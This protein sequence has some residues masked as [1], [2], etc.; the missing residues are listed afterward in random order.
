MKILL[1]KLQSEWEN[2]KGKFNNI[3][4]AKYKDQCSIDIYDDLLDSSNR[5]IFRLQMQSFEQVNR[6]AFDFILEYL[7]TK[8]LEESDILQFILDKREYKS[9]KNK[10]KVVE[11]TNGGLK[12]D[13]GF[14]LIHV[15][16]SWANVWADWEVLNDQSLF[17]KVEFDYEILKSCQSVENSGINIHSLCGQRFFVPCYEG[18]GGYYTGS[19]Y[20]KL[21]DSNG[22]LLDT[23]NFTEGTKYLP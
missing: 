18:T 20:L 5:L 22:T 10:I 6:L 12:F 21:E 11:V 3:S 9:I 8:C 4:W 16:E 23:A 1:D 14:K 7:E 17:F 19:L 15:T 13:N 2:E